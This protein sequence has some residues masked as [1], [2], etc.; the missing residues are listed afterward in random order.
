M[1]SFHLL[2]SLNCHIYIDIFC[3][4]IERE[5]DNSLFQARISQ[6]ALELLNLPDDGVPRLL[7]DIGLI[8][9]FYFLYPSFQ[10]GKFINL[11]LIF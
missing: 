9:L 11:I 2:V 10:F 3:L 6:R 5:L 1:R 4:T 7:L 8:M